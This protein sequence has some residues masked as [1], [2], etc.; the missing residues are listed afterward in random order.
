MKF[1]RIFVIDD[2]TIIHTIQKLLLQEYFPENF[3]ER[4]DDSTRAL[5][6]L[7]S[8]DEDVKEILIFLDLNMPVLSG[9]QLL[10]KLQENGIH[11]NI[12][13]FI[14]TFSN[15]T[16]EIEK[17]NSHSYV[18]KVIRKPLTREKL[19]ELDI[20]RSRGI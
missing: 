13:V 14:L 5:D 1:D 12:T 11:Y 2:D 4:Y 19:A 8:M 18:K 7:L 9:L 6:R 3:L 17:V 15:N 10:D 16:A 20:V